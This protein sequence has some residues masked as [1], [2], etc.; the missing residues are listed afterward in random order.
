MTSPCLLTAAWVLPI[1]KP[2]LA[3]GSVL[4]ANGRIVAVGTRTELRRAHPGVP[5]RNLGATALLPGLV[6]AHTHLSLT[7][8]EEGRPEAGDYLQ[9]LGWVARSARGLT[10][11][12]VRAA[13]SRGVEECVSLGTVL[14][15]E[16]TSRA[17]G[18]E[19]LT[20]HPALHARV[21]FE[22]LGLSKARAHEQF[23]KAR[24]RAT[25]LDADSHPRVRPGLS[26]HAPYSV[27]PTLWRE[28][29]ELCRRSDWR[30]SSHVLEPESE[31]S[32]LVHGS[33][34]LRDQF[35]RVGFWDPA[36]P[37]PGVPP[38]ELLERADALGPEA[39]L[40]HLVQAGPQE[41]ALLGRH[42][43]PVCLCPRSN[44]FLGLAPAA[45]LE[46]TAAG[47]PLCLGTD[48]RASNEDLSMWG[49]M[50]ALAALWP[51][52][53]PRVILEMA[54]LN[55]AIA[56]GFE[57]SLGSISPGKQ[58]LLL[59]V[60]M[61]AEGPEEVEALLVRSGSPAGLERIGW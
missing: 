24:Q 40:V 11:D 6:N 16:I 9:W 10:E 53:K 37:V 45:A 34:P 5:E 1:R 46:L 18:V 21:F 36:F 31:R 38:L 60:P 22:F 15:G 55:G 39:L 13:S 2:P 54:T 44:A 59:G 43:T 52:L 33:G 28:A 7:D 3:G 56:L 4:V 32:F 17:E 29:A 41:I 30:W 58:A 50:A 61:D 20:R 23:R 12:A 19:H 25:A 51:D 47:V 27:W 8:L 42:G 49:E 57:D 14:V 48:S 35:E 26:P